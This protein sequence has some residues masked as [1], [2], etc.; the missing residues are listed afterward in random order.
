MKWNTKKGNPNGQIRNHRARN[1]EMNNMKNL[2]QCA[3]HYIY[4]LLLYINSDFSLFICSFVCCSSRFPACSSFIL[5]YSIHFAYSESLD[6]SHNQN[7]RDKS[8]S[9]KISTMLSTMDA[10]IAFII[11]DL[12]SKHPIASKRRYF[13]IA[14]ACVCY[15]ATLIIMLTILTTLIQGSGAP[16]QCNRRCV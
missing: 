8:A 1:T 7:E 12:K 15:K 5:T 6:S 3:I 10:T 13:T 4:S 2:I 9:T 14:F 16:P 11:D